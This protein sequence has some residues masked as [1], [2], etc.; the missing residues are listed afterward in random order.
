MVDLVF[1]SMQPPLAELKQLFGLSGA[2]VA[3]LFN[4][5]RQAVNYWEETGVIPRGRREKLANLLSVGRMLDSQLGAGHLPIVARRKAKVTGG[6][7][8]LEIA[9]QDSDG[10]LLEMT[11][12]GFDWSSI[13]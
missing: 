1:R 8:M 12:R 2:E 3:D 5:S 7:T 9:A 10:K 6:L 11:E 4:V 13:A